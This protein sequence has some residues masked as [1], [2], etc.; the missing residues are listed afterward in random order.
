MNPELCREL[1]DA[2]HGD[3]FPVRTFRD[4]PTRL[5]EVANRILR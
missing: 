3:V 5:L 2:G 4:L 1:A